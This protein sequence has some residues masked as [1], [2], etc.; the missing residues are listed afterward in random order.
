MSSLFAKDNATEVIMLLCYT[1]NFSDYF[2][3]PSYISLDIGQLK[4]DFCNLDLMKVASELM[5]EFDVYNSIL[6]EVNI[7]ML[8]Y[9]FYENNGT[10]L[11]QNR[12]EFEL[13][14]LS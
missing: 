9:K 5:V 6:T 2:T 14:G 3:V 8:I 12:K 11:C 4:T 13:S 10:L 7:Y 1:G